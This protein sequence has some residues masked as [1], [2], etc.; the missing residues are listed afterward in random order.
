VK[1]R[2]IEAAVDLPEIEHVKLSQVDKNKR[3][4]T[5]LKAHVKISPSGR[6]RIAMKTRKGGLQ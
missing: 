6:H 2:D 4:S 5:R 3:R 1:I